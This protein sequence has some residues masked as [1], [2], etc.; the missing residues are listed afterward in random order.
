MT[1]IMDKIN[2]WPRNQKGELLFKTSEGAIAY[3]VLV[4]R[5]KKEIAE[6]KKFRD[7]SYRQI[8]LEKARKVPS[9]QRL[10]DL[11][12]KGQFF[13]E[14]YEEAERLEKYDISLK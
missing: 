7:E 10:F 4:S 14:A 6:L 13:R 11:A 9:I 8:D 3:G 5:H 1:K 2:Q 12:F